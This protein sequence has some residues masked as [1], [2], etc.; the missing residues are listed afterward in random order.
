MYDDIDI[1]SHHTEL[2]H[3]TLE[4]HPTSLSTQAPAAHRCCFVICI[5]EV[6]A[7]V[8]LHTH[9][10]IYVFLY[11]CIP[12]FIIVKLREREGQRVVL[13]RSLKGHL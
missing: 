4:L 5:D 6:S 12:I 3:L 11:F 2:F 8:V 9:A 1:I 7:L 13:G 10:E